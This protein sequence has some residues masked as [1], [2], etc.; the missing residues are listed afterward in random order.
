MLPSPK[1]KPISTEPL[2]TAGRV[3]A[4]RVDGTLVTVLLVLLR[5]YQLLLS[6]LFAGSCRFFPSCSNY[7]AEAVRTHGA[8]RGTWLGC[9]RLLR[10]HPLGGH[11]VDPVPHS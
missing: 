7:M 9:R 11:G 6:P 4:R 1:L 8:W 2:R 3:L 10:C 5:G